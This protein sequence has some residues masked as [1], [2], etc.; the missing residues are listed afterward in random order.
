MFSFLFV[1]WK[2]QA[3]LAWRASADLSIFP[4]LPVNS[5]LRQRTLILVNQIV[6]GPC[7]LL[8]IFSIS[9]KLIL[10]SYSSRLYT[11]SFRNSQPEIHSKTSLLSSLKALVPFTIPLL[12]AIFLL[13]LLFIFHNEIEMMVSDNALDDYNTM[14][15]SDGFHSISLPDGRH[16]KISYEQNSLRVFS[17]EV[18][19]N[20]SI[21]S[22]EFA[23]LSQDILVTTGDFQDPTRVSVMVS[24]HHFTWK[25]KDGSYPQGSIHLLHT[26][27]MDQTIFMQLRQ[28]EAGQIVSI[29]GY[30]IYRIEGWD[31]TGKY[32]GYWQDSGCNT[33]LVTEVIIGE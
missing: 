16:W 13:I 17:G 10:T 24:N 18:S 19:H 33:I 1:C 15:V 27:P 20:S 25:S 28:L 7:A 30:E 12:V 6:S 11:M 3:C 21:H 26:M 31:N 4:V 2:V 14:I 32:I 29:K 23:I 9:Y 5:A 8:S 22:G